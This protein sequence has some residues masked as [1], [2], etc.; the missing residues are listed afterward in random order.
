MTETGKRRKNR[1]CDQSKG[2]GGVMLLYGPR[3]N[4]RDRLSEFMLQVLE[5]RPAMAVRVLSRRPLHRLW[6]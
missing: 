6:C 4:N 5:D 2:G 1:Y 3:T